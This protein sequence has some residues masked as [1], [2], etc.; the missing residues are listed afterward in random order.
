M[1]RKGLVIVKKI[2]IKYMKNSTVENKKA[3]LG[4]KRIQNKL[5]RQC[6][7]NYYDSQF[8]Q[9]VGNIRK[10]WEI[11]REVINRKKN[12]KKSDMFVINGSK[13]DDTAQIAN[14]FN[15]FYLNI[16][17]NISQSL[18]PANRHYSSFMPNA[19]PNTIFLTPVTNNEIKT[20][21]L[22]FNKKSPGWDGLTSTILKDTY[23]YILETLTC[24]INK[25]ISEGVFP[26]E[27]KIAKV[28]PL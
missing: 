1:L 4:Y 13:V 2:Y 28:I 14:S 26:N 3:Y 9:N 18:P 15:E 23:P 16:A 19:N 25:S 24:L 17:D 8:Q 12:K 6:E 5:F 10:S 21:I 7:R 11:I 20:I 27:L 22:N